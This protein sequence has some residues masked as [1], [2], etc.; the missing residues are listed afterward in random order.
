L[1]ALIKASALI[2]DTSGMSDVFR[3]AGEFGVTKG[4]CEF[5]ESVAR[6]GDLTAIGVWNVILPKTHQ[7]MDCVR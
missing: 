3:E 5:K 2:R 6:T 7:S 1:L 4:A